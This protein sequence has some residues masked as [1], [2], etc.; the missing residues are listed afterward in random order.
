M[1][2]YLDTSVLVSI[3]TGEIDPDA[4]EAV[5]TGRSRALVISPWVVTEMSAALSAKLRNREI[6]DHLRQRALSTFAVFV[7]QSFEIWPVRSRH[8]KHAARLAEDQAL[9]LK[10]GDALHMALVV[11]RK[12]ALCTLDK[13]MRAAALALGLAVVDP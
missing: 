12:A 3:L 10:G 6:D 4:G 1:S 11:E 9:A 5:L 13:T 8:F 2:L 7:D